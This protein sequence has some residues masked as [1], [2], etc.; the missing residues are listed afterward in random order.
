MTDKENNKKTIEEELEPFFDE[1]PSVTIKGKPYKMRRLGIAD[2]FKLGRIIAV[3]AAGVGKEIGKLELSP[4]VL[5]GL[6]FVG[7][8]YAEKPIMEFLATV[9][10]VTYEEIKDP[11]KFPMGSE[12]DIINALVT[13]I[14][15]KAFFDRLTSLM[16]T[17]MFK[18]FLRK[19]STSSKKDM[20]GRTSI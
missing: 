15:V 6:M 13:H 20:V 9:I 4:E 3:G 17:P 2:T 8:P 5:A 12:V 11:R 1:A 7:F 14:D 10:G 19:T 18:G 16:K